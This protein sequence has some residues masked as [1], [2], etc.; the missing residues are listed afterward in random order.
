MMV[1]TALSCVKLSNALVYVFLGVF[2]IT[3]YG[4]FTHRKRI[5]GP[6]ALPII[7]NA[8]TFIRMKQRSH[9]EL[10]KLREK[11]GD[12]FRL[13]LG[14][15][16]L[17]VISGYEN[18]YEA[19][20]KHGLVFSHRPN[21]LSDI[22]TR[23]EKYG[24][25]I[26]WGNG[27]EWRRQRRFALQM[28]KNFGVGK[29]SHEKII[30]DEAK[31]LCEEFA[32]RE[33]QP[34]DDVKAM[35]TITI[36]NVIHHVTFG[37]RYHHDDKRF[38]RL[39]KLY[40]E[41]F[42]GP[43]PL[44]VSLPKW[45]HLGQ[46][47]ADIKSSR[48]SL[49]CIID[50]IAD[51]IADHEKTYDENNIRDFVDLYI[52]AQ[53]A[54]GE[55]EKGDE[56]K[57]H[58]FQVI[59]DMFSAATETTGTTLDWAL[60]FLIAYPEVQE[61]CFNYIKKIVGLGREV[62]LSDKKSLPYIEATIMEIQRLSNI[63]S[64]S[65]AHMNIEDVEIAGYIIPK[66]SM[67]IGFL[68][69]AHLDPKLFPQPRQFQPERFLNEDTGKL[70]PQD[71]FIPFSLGPRACP[72]DFFAKNQMFLVLS[73]LIQRFRF[74]KVSD[75]DVLDFAGVTGITTSACPYRLKVEDRHH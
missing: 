16:Q 64:M 54:D 71:G 57:H 46:L 66:N 61:K 65:V 40:D 68:A 49:S 45:Y 41:V 36:S 25:G 44:L 17:I 42:K 6:F 63:A 9:I 29:K 39:I 32:T 15:F 4:L 69:T 67:V 35:M 72:G 24:Y 53:R 51:Q 48:A 33:G 52:Q 26:L 27:E 50:Y 3:L 60:L 58:M 1:L 11:Y 12:V 43:S 38:L 20:V 37:F 8:L 7:G 10:L 23:A 18:I 28:M 47:K 19:F 34:I 62:Q 2:I 22:K 55:T 70:A 56:S 5:P 31:M 21:W 13:Y 75:D 59:L 74:S 14:P 73:N 30:L